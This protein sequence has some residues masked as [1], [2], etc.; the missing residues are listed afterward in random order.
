VSASW[1]LAEEIPIGWL[2][3]PYV[4]STKHIDVSTLVMIAAKVA[5]DM[6]LFFFPLDERNSGTG[7]SKRRRG[8][9]VRVYLEGWPCT[10]S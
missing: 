4:V 7:N 5:K 3:A 2:S 8:V 1:A 9:A 10:A 6:R